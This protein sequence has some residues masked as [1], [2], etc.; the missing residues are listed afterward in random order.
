MAH[1]ARSPLLTLATLVAGGATW[2]L[3]KWGSSAGVALADE[4][5]IA[6]SPN[7]F[8]KFNL[9]KTNSVSH[10]TSVFRFELPSPEHETGLTVASC[11]LARAEIEGKTVVRPYT[12]TSLNAQR[13]FVDLMVKSYPAPGGQMSRHIHSLRPGSGFLELKGPFKKLEYKPNM[14]R[15]IGMVAGGTG[16]A[17]MLQ[18]IREV[19]SNPED[20]TE[21]SLVFANVSE[22][23][24]LLRDELDA[25]QYLYPNFKIFYTLDKPPRGWKFGAG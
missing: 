5:K 14:K 12:P 23:D 8:R 24:I 4:K 17:P 22:S 21:V 13:G 3:T 1:R 11:V 16:I 6:L 10:N 20:A 2:Q 25:L 7:E 19:L 15:K 9:V 18:I